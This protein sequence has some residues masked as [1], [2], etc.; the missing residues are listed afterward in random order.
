MMN[1]VSQSSRRSWTVLCLVFAFLAASVT[2]HAAHAADPDFENWL[3][4]QAQISMDKMVANISPADAA[5]GAVVA[6]PSRSNP[7]YFYFWVR[8]AALVMDVFARQ[9]VVASGPVKGQ[10]WRMMDEYVDF[11]RGNQMTQTITGLGEPKFFANGAPFN[12]P[13]GR[14]QNDS[15]ALRATTLIRFANQLLNEG[16]DGYVRH[17]LYNNTIPAYTVIKS[18]LEFVSHHWRDPS[19]DLWEE[20]M[21]DHFYTRMV[22]LAA[23]REGSAL[24]ARMGDGGAAGFYQDQAKQIENS[25]RG[26]WREDRGIYRVRLKWRG[27]I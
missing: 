9:Y 12:D 8:D 15:P 7:N 3:G 16:S 5:R 13:W 19:F 22:Q 24:A 11:S 10:L 26:F 2:G 17:K 25:L 18:D 20:V 14:P 23:M 4:H 21:G 27:G 6:S 1:S